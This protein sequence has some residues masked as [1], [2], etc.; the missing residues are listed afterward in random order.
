MAENASHWSN[1][2]SLSFRKPKGIAATL[3]RTAIRLRRLFGSEIQENAADA[4]EAVGYFLN[5][6]ASV[7]ARTYPA[8]HKIL[9]E[10]L[11]EYP[12]T[13]DERRNLLEA[14]PIDDY[15]F[16]GVVA[17]EA[18]RIRDLYLPAE[19]AEL[20]GE[21]GEQV[22]DAAG[23]HDRIVSDLVFDMLGRIGRGTGV[24]RMKTPY[25]NVVKTILKHMGIDKNEATRG[26]LR[27]IG[28]RHLL[29]EPLAIGVPHWWRAFH[30][31]FRLYWAEPE[32]L[33][34]EQTEIAL[35]TLAAAN[36]HAPK[37]R[38]APR[39]AVSFFN[40]N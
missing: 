29:G 32:V 18:A 12:L 16:A 14:H 27:D 1:K 17:L 7:A 24:D 21:I 15:F 30:A 22:D 34:D 39:R 2:S 20:L 19:T 28:L 35:L 37:R 8:W 9:N 36:V 26:V 40:G 5:E 25:D 11:A 3:Q 6:M 13:Q 4:K 31:K 38:R 33:G 10:G 23:R